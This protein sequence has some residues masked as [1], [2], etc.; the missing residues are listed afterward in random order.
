M[1]GSNLGELEELILLSVAALYDDAYG[2]SI[3]NF[4]HE[5]CDRSIS[6]SSVHTVLQRLL[7]KGY[8][9]S[10]YG[11]A[12]DSRGGRRKHLFT[13]T[14]AGRKALTAVRDQRN[15]LWNSISKLA[16]K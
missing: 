4:V 6:I 9:N 15:Q 2:I 14:I 5:R 7:A 11:G 13:V 16:F 8:L 3:Q 12:T 1:K 10:R